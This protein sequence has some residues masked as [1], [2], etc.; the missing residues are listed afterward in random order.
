VADRR[1][2][3]DRSPAAPRR[4][5]ADGLVVGRLQAYG[6]ANYQFSAQQS[7][8]YYIK[9]LTNRGVRTLWGSDLARALAAAVTQPQIGDLVGAQRIGHEAVTLPASARKREADGA[10]AAENV[11]PVYRNHWRVEKV[12]FFAERVR[13]ARQVRKAHA[14]V[15]AEMREHPELKST[16]LSLRAAEEF[17]MRRIADPEDRKL[18][19]ERVRGAMA[20]SIRKNEPV[21]EARL[22][23][24]A[25]T[26]RTSVP[27]D[28]SRKTERTR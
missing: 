1:Q 13:L 9:L 21:P 27:E 26:E 15:Q 11:Q 20:A 17:A 10:G 4:F 5:R 24:R 19:V 25:V 18:F 7:P 16:F 2:S 23:A 14:E 12:Q 3:A 8:S 6:R 28:R 22:R